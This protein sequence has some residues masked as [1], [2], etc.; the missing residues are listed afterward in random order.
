MIPG[1]LTLLSGCGQGR[2]ETYPTRGKVVFS[3]GSPVRLGTIELLSE[4]HKI[5]ATGTI[6]QD[7][8]FVLGTFTPSDGAC[9]GKHIA[10][11]TQ[12]IVNDGLTKHQLDHG[13]PVDPAYASYSTSPLFVVI[14]AKDMNDIELKVEKAIMK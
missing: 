10:I 4:E 1:L 2:P 7:G 3:D 8:S 9:A 11:V 12:L 13:A 14:E 5:N 6:Q